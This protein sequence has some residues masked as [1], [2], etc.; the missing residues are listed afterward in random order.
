MPDDVSENAKL[1]RGVS[2]TVATDRVVVR[3]RAGSLGWQPIVGIVA[4]AIVFSVCAAVFLRVIALIRSGAAANPGPALFLSI[5]GT[6]SGF[7][8]VA[9]CLWAMVGHE[10]LV[11]L[12]RRLA[13]SNPWL[14]GLPTRA[15]D[16]GEV[17]PFTCSE[18]ECG[19]RAEE[20]SCCCRWSS[21]DY[22]LSFGY[23]DTRVRVFPQL[24]RQAKDWLRD[25]LNDALRTAPDSG[26]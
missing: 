10:K 19:V 17:K 7:Y 24:P 14:L 8:C 4:S 25:R 18:R 9:L 6:L 15:F 26:V 1:P 12:R 3:T 2:L 20:N 5:L 11:I 23:R 21:V 16:L 22:S 13:I